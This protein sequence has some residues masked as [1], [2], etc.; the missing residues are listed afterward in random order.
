MSAL[1]QAQFE[2]TEDLATLVLWIKSQGLRCKITECGVA[3]VR[4][5]YIEDTKSIIN[6]AVHIPVSNHYRNLAADIEIFFHDDN[7]PREEDKW[8]LVKRS[9]DPIYKRLATAWCALRPD[10]RTGIGFDDANHVARL[11]N[12]VI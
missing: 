4:K 3:Y 9:D 6:D 8:K 12:G 5:A 1:L 11:W 2:F 7:E 10:N